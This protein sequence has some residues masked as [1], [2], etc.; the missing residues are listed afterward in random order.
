MS[1]GAILQL[2]ATG[3][4]DIYLTGEPQM[5]YWKSTYRRYTN[6]AVES[7]ELPIAGT[8]NTGAKVSITIP[9]TGDLLKSLW[10]HYNPSELIAKSTDLEPQNIIFPTNNDPT[11]AFLSPVIKITSEKKIINKKIKYFL[12]L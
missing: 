4:Q 3:A 6:Y 8:I 1:S 10:I 5:T 7:V 9:K 2:V 12:T 11:K